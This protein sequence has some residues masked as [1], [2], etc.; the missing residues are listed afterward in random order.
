M[1]KIFTL[2]VF[3]SLIFSSIGSYAQTEDFGIRFGAELTK[4]LGKKFELGI[5]EE[6][7]LNQNA[8]EIDRFLTSFGAKYEISKLFDVGAYYTWIYANNQKDDY[9]ENRHRFGT[10]IK[11][12]KKV[13]RFKFSLKEQLMITYRD[14][15]LGTYKYNP[16][17]YLRSRFEVSYNVKNSPIKPYLSAQM[18]Y[19]LNNPSGNV[20]DQ[21]R[22]VAGMEYDIN[23]KFTIDAYLMRDEEVNVKKPLNTTVVGTMLKFKL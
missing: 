15:N 13:N 23:K 21:W 22:Y 9:Y 10:W 8:S 12:G 19:Q 4:E 16:K 6:G 14:E 1:K 11:A 5:Q 7:R 17:T 3:V 2:V 18:H 20:I